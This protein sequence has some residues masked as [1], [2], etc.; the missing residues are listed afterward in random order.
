M[1]YYRLWDLET[2]RVVI[3][4]DNAF[5]KESIRIVSL[6]SISTKESLEEELKRSIDW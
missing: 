3:T 6:E 4:I 1:S 2:K 5:N